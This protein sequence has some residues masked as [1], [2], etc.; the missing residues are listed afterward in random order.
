MRQQQGEEAEAFDG[1]LIA[2]CG[3]Y[4]CIHGAIYLIYTITVWTSGDT[5]IGGLLYALAVAA[6]IGL[7]SLF[8]VLILGLVGRRMRRRSL[9]LILAGLLTPL[10]VILG[11]NGLPP[12]LYELAVQWLFAFTCPAPPP[13]MRGRQ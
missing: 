1:W 8:V 12:M 13:R 7:P 10:A 5:M 11:F 4:L 3:M 2:C 9:Q 6:F